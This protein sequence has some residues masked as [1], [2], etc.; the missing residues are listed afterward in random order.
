MRLIE[1]FDRFLRDEVNLNQTRIDN[2][3]SKV[4]AITRFLETSDWT[5]SIREFSHQG[6]WAHGTIIKPPGSKGFDADLLVLI[7]EVPGWTA[8]EYIDTLCQVF[9]ASGIY[10]DKVIKGTRCVTIDYAGD[11]HLDVVPCVVNRSGEQRSE[12]CNRRDDT[13]E[14][15]D[16]EGY[17]QWWQTRNGWTRNDNLKRATRLIKYLRDIK[18]TFS[19]KSIL[20]T[21]LLG[22][23]VTEYDPY[24]PSAPFQDLPTTLKT[25]IGRLDDFLQQNPSMPT[26]CNPVL[27]QETFV[28][29]WDAD[30]YANFR[31][32]IHKYREWIDDA[33]N[34]PD[35]DESIAKWRK[36]FRDEFA[37]SVVIEEA[38]SIR[39]RIVG[40]TS[41]YPIGDAVNAVMALG[42]AALERIPT[43][44]PWVERSPW[45]MAGGISVTVRATLYTARDGSPVR[46]ITSAEPLG[47]GRHILFEAVNAVGS[48]FPAA[49]YDVQWRVVNTDQDAINARA[50]RGGF[51]K[52]DTASRRWEKTEYRGA[53]W[54]EA[55]VIRKRDNA[56]VGQSGRFWVVIE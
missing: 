7:D 53:H 4:E 23:R 38:R 29:H 30:K 37:S 15:T 25:L 52:A 31:D 39:A 19:V 36:V 50:L 51:Y 24:L 16:G 35:R 43:T 49:D 34:E 55:F 2:L 56:C 47:R 48:P 12:V 42:R 14:L 5:P 8:A 21:T 54:V 18:L 9:S 41:A 33:Y 6:S 13:F 3:E 22:E 1:H 20:L 32:Q 27:P 17:A 40:T 46:M 44:L 11:F 10:R 45:R 28:R 26:I